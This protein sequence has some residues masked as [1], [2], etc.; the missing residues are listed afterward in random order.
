MI[1]LK[2]YIK[3]INESKETLFVSSPKSQILPRL[4]GLFIYDYMEFETTNYGSCY[5]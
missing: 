5:Y 1:N 2:E 4:I 3:Q